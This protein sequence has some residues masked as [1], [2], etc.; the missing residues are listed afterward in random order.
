MR[1]RAH[2]A[3]VVGQRLALLRLSRLHASAIDA[4]R[5]SPCLPGL[6]PS[7]QQRLSGQPRFA[8]RLSARIATRYNLPSLSIDDD[9]PRIHLLLKGR[10]AVRRLIRLAGAV[11]HVGVLR[12]VVLAAERRALDTALGADI[13][14]FALRHVHLAPRTMPA[15][16][17][18]DPADVIDRSGAACFAVWIKDWP[19]AYLSRLNIM[20]PPQIWPAH[21]SIEHAT[22]GPRILEA[23]LSEGMRS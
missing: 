17:A 14:P 10:P 21:A 4:A 11:W 13:I 23:T 2:T 15:A 1:S 6:S 12:R 18:G 19:E 8:E 16:L 22:Y 9:D 5:L 7:L 3:E 20:L